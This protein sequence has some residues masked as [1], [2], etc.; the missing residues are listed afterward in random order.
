M[1]FTRSPKSKNKGTD[2]HP[3]TMSNPVSRAAADLQDERLL[4]DDGLRGAVVA[5]GRRVRAGDLGS[6]PVVVG[7]VVIWVAFGILTPGGSFLYATNLV[8]LAVQCA[9]AGTISIGIVLVLL[10]G[11]IDLSVGSVS[12]LAAAILGVGLTLHGWPILLVIVVALAVG[13]AIGALY[14]LLFT[15]FGVPSFVITLA[16]LLAFLGVQLLVLGANGS[17]NLPQDSF[18]VQF[19]LFS[20]LPPWLVYLLVVLAAGGTLFADIRRN[21]RRRRAGLSVGL[22]SLVYIKSAALLVGLGVIAWYLS[23]DRGTG[24]SFV[25]FVVLVVVMNYLVT[26]TRWGRSIYAVGGNVEAARRAG[27]NVRW[28]YISVFMLCSMF[29]VV[30]GLLSA[31]HLSASTLSSGG[32]DVNL[33]AIAAAV[34]GGTSL[35][36]GRGRIWS[37]LLGVIVIQSIANGLNLLNFD[38]YTRYIVTGAVLLLA[39]I[40]D[41][42]SRRSRASHGAA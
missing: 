40:I 25:F 41:S 38:D 34:I 26:R 3:L 5:F 2:P 39:V 8:D 18:L 13:A 1:S 7:L 11:E 19:A 20:Y 27:I 17:I 33:N 16:G 4:R 10:L 31:A 21:A 32:G 36:G 14:G 28:V 24:S 22:S 30:G 23:T 9:A 29:A 37:A 6:L 12:G 35:F 42:L 15:R